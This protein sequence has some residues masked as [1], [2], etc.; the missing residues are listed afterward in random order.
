MHGKDNQ[1][2]FKGFP[3]TLDV[4]TENYFNEYLDKQ[5][6]SSSE[7]VYIIKGDLHQSAITQ[8]KRFTYV[9]VSSLFGSSD[10]IMANFGNT[11][12]GCDYMTISKT[13]LVAHGLIRD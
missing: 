8:G 5:G 10:W 1:N 7:E 6:I 9:S 12:W 2:Q 13:G 4:K 11:P 3:L